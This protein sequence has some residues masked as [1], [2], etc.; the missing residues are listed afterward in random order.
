M[1]NPNNNIIDDKLP[2]ILDG[3]RKTIFQDKESADFT[4]NCQNVTVRKNGKKL[5]MYSISTAHEITGAVCVVSRIFKTCNKYLLARHWRVS[6]KK[7]HWEFPRGMG[8]KGESP[9]ETALRELFEETGIK[10]YSHI[11]ILQKIYADTGVL[12]GDI[13]VAHI[14]MPFTSEEEENSKLN[15]KTDWELSNLC[16]FSFNEI[17]SMIKNNEIDDGITLSAWCIYCSKNLIQS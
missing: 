5:R 2:L 9:E 1:T 8:I 15:N 4:V 17:I 16:W 3:E 12:N 14:S 10:N 6:T 13:A 7:W 11:N